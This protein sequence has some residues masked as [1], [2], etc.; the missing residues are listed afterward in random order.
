MGSTPEHIPTLQIMNE[1]HEIRMEVK[2]L[3]NM[4]GVDV[5]HYVLQILDP[6]TV[7]DEL[8]SSGAIQVDHAQR[9]IRY[10][11]IPEEYLTLTCYHEIICS[12]NTGWPAPVWDDCRDAVQMELKQ[13]HTRAFL[14]WRRDFFKGMKN[15]Y[16]RL[17]KKAQEVGKVDERKEWGRMQDQ[18]VIS[19]MFLEI[20]LGRKN[21]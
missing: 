13:P 6:A 18:M 2:W 9:I 20:Q 10:A 5:P 11:N 17:R 12:Q 21:P 3:Q 1:P 7:P 19:Q 16:A 8:A 4:N 14:E 15:Y